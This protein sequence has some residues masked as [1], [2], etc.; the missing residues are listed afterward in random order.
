M[1][2]AAVASSFAFLAAAGLLAGCP[3]RTISE[4][5]PLQGRVEFKDIPVNKTRDIDLLFVIDDSPSML[6]KQTNLKN[7]FQRFIDVLSTIPGGL[8]S[9]H[10]GVVTSDMGT[11][12]ALDSNPSFGSQ[13]GKVGNGGCKENGKNGDLQLTGLAGMTTD[14][15][16]FLSDLEPTMDG[17][18]RR[19]NYNGSLKDAFGQMAVV[20]AGGCGFEQH[21]EA[22]KAAL[23]P[24]NVVNAEF[25]RPDAYL[26]VI[27]I[28][29]EDDCSLS[30]YSLLGTDQASIVELGAPQSF[31][32]T[33]FGVL[34]NQGGETTDEM[35]EVGTKSQCHPNDESRYLTNV[36][37][38]AAFLKNLKP[39][40][41]TKVIV[42]G[43]MGTTDVIKTELRRPQGTP[44]GTP[45]VEALAHSCTYV[46]ADGI[47]VA[48]PPIR[49]KFFLDQFPNRSTFVSICQPDLSGGLQQIAELLK[50]VL[51]DPCINGQLADVDPDT[52]GDQFDCSV[53]AVTKQGTVDQ[54]E[55]VLPRCP[56]SGGSTA[57]PCWHIVKD[58][59][60]CPGL[61]P[62]AP[63]SQHLMLLFDG[64]EDNPNPLYKDAHLVANC[65]TEVNN[66]K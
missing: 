58:E 1:R 26:A 66:S 61:P 35:N 21:L 45:E 64:I 37:E 10:I 31:R 4:V 63:P 20:G 48:D 65:V 11:R 39:S 51:G 12:G 53:S 41:P 49:L 30:H 50:T 7:N 25:L 54:T 59:A 52:A 13:I 24:S 28:A 34:C 18:P 9:V 55:T 56:A 60:K 17:G 23:Q 2:H 36:A 33:R 62:P 47:E 42:A 14:G 15:A 8:P 29:D 40:D 27:F 6:D 5:D 32:C 19:P 46:G 38:Y 44:E 43:I 3:D 16:P 22:M 57:Q